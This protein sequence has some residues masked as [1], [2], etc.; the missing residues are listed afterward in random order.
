MVKSMIKHIYL[1]Y[2][3]SGEVVNI[4][5]YILNKYSTKKVKIKV[6][7]EALSGRKLSVK[8]LK[9]FWSLCFKHISDQRRNKLDDK[10]KRMVLIEYHSTWAYKL[11]ISRDVVFNESEAWNW[12]DT[13]EKGSDSNHV[14]VKAVKNEGSNKEFDVKDIK[15]ANDW[16][17]ETQIHVERP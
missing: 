5:T 14:F 4:I 1:A 12:Q 7:E 6:L 15:V 11:Y 3:L 8:Y 10:N 17:I 2:I 16:P 13:S 9:V